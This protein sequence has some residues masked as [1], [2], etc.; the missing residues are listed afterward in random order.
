MKVAASPQI[1]M[2]RCPKAGIPVTSHSSLLS[3][4]Q[5][6][7]KERENAS[8]VRRLREHPI[9]RWRGSPFLCG[10]GLSGATLRVD[11]L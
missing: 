9:H 8:Q 11:F 2:R 7:E 1:F 3:N 10:E 4:F 6:Y 5:R